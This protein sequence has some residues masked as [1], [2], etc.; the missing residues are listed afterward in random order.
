MDKMDLSQAQGHWVLAK[1]GKKVLRPG[2]KELTIKMI[3]ALNI[4]DKSD[5]VEFAPGLGYTASQ[6]LQ[7][8][9]KS[10]TAIEKDEKAAKDLNYLMNQDNRRIVNGDATTTNL[11]DNCADVVYG[12]A[13]LSMQADHRKLEIV[14]EAYRILR[15]G[16]VYGIHELGLQPNDLPEDKKAKIQK[17]LAKTIRVNARPLTF[18]EWSSVL[19][20]AG[21]TIKKIETNEMNLLETKRIID[22]EGFFRTLKIGFRILTNHK[23]FKRVMHMKKTFRKYQQN[24][25]AVSIVAVK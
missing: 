6:V 9:P 24:L 18:D 10:Y 3:N 12:E 1:M 2:G 14:K 17:D 23:A 11:S 4:T 22:D 5:V 19:I 13:M 16:G 8:N 21:F 7:N 15:K 20:E 25:N